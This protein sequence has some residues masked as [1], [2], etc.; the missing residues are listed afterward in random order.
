MVELAAAQ[1]EDV[2][3]ASGEST[4]LE[5]FTGKSQ[6]LALFE[7]SS[8]F[9]ED[10]TVLMEADGAAEGEA[11][12]VDEDIEDMDGDAIGSGDEG[13][14]LVGVSDDGK[15]VVIKLDDGEPDEY[16]VLHASYDGDLAGPFTSMVFD[17]D[18]IYMTSESS[19]GLYKIDLPIV[20][21]DWC[22]DSEKLEEICYYNEDEGEAEDEE[23]MPQITYAGPADA[24]GT[25]GLLCGALTFEETQP[26]YAPTPAPSPA[27]PSSACGTASS[28]SRFARGG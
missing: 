11:E 23:Y 22:W 2:G 7:L 1:L 18:A 28:R 4:V 19:D 9:S 25:S 3:R 6:L 20:V 13:E 15:V 26:S 16:A 8:V 10:V 27:P 17:G 21:G 24:G 14:Y 5:T 12:D